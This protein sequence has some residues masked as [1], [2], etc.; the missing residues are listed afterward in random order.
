MSTFKWINDQVPE[1]LKISQVYAIAFSDDGNILLRIEDGKYQLTGGHPDKKETFNETVSREY[2]EEVN[3]VIDEIYYLGYLLVDDENG[4]PNYA[5][6]RMIA[7]IK[8]I[9]EIRPDLDNG[10]I[11]KRYL[12]NISNV[13]KYLNYPGDAGNDMLDDAIKLALEKYKFKE[14]KEECFI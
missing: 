7:R 8:N 1:N 10:K 4:S 11:Y 5:Q 9:G 13:K 2:I 12:A 14:C 3:I 6:V